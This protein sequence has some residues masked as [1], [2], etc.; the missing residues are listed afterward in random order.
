MH[1]PIP[2]PA[3]E[4]FSHLAHPDEVFKVA[5]LLSDTVLSLPMHGLITLVEVETV[6]KAII[7]SLED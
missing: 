7:E 2:L 4:A 6:A 1:Y 3:Q 5:G